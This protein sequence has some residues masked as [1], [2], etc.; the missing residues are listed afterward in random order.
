VVEFAWSLP[1]RLKVRDGQTKWALRKVLKRH[2][3]DA[4]IDRGKTGFGVPLAA[5]LRG[6]LRGWAEDLLDARRLGEDGLLDP[7]PIRA[8]WS[9]HLSGA[10]DWHYYLWDVLMLESWKRTARAAT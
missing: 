2:L 4:L 6:P 7:A 10:R 8:M 1:E 5:W 9:E 3:P